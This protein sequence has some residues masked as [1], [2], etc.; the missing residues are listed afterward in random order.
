MCDR[1]IIRR[2]R[3]SKD[4]WKFCTKCFGLVFEPNNADSDCP[5]GGIHTPQGF[6]F[7]LDHT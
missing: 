2:D 1:F 4:N 7:R 6:N 5:A 3:R